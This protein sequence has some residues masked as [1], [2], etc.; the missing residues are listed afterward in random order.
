MHSD[1]TRPGT[2][3]DA[4]RVSVVMSVYNGLPLV[5]DAVDSILGQ[6]LRDLEF[7]IVND[8]ST[9]DTL[10]YLQSAAA[11]DP[12]IRIVDQANTGLT[13]ALVRGVAAARAPLIARMDADDIS[14]PRRL[15]AQADYLDANPG[16]CAVS[17]GITYVG[18]NMEL[19]ATSDR[20]RP[21]G[22]I[23]LLMTLYNAI[24]GHGHVVFRKSAYDRAGGYDPQFRYAQDYDLWTRM[25]RLGPF[26]EVPG[27]LYKFRIDHDSISTRHS[28][29]QLALATQIASREFTHL[30]GSIPNVDTVGLIHAI[31]QQ[32]CP[33]TAD[34][35]K[36]LAANRHMKR[37]VSAY[38]KKYPDRKPV[39]PIVRSEIGALWRSLFNSL[40]YRREPRLV[41]I[42][43]IAA[44]WDFKF[45][46]CALMRRIHRAER[47]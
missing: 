35:G 6:T 42:A 29:A 30:T 39:L 47:G 10:S 33:D 16:L 5:I 46:F 12:R 9:D 2:Q 41:L 3:S 32:K 37:A 8:G 26:G 11:A 31:W 25:M 34:M 17:C 13:R 22:A 43:A 15:E 28:G 7:I 21:S 40:R 20:Q 23:P 1:G 38:F 18:G 19:I 44:L 27:L 14:E 24:S 4:P 45:F 36:L